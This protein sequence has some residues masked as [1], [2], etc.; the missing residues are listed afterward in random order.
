MADFTDTPAG[1]KFLASLND[2]AEIFRDEL[3]PGCIVS[4]VTVRGGMGLGAYPGVRVQARRKPSSKFWADLDVFLHWPVPE[5]IGFANASQEE[6]ERC[7]EALR[8]SAGAQLSAALNT[9]SV[10]L[11]TFSQGYNESV[12]IELQGLYI[13][14]DSTEGSDDPSA[15]LP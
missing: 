1:A 12:W 6:R 8:W 7:L 9:R 10:D 13:A 15:M 5:V 11:N 2:I 14:P 4:A 3:D